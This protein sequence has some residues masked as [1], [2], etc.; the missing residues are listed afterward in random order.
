MPFLLCLVGGLEG[1]QLYFQGFGWFL[2]LVLGAGEVPVLDAECAF[3][4]VLGSDVLIGVVAVFSGVDVPVLLAAAG[5]GVR[6]PPQQVDRLPHVPF[7]PGPA[8]V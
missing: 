6:V 4:E 5:L 8:H 3:C 2:L 1:V 7:G